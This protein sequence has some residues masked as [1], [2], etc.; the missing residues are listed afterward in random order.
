MAGLS[1]PLKS[2]LAQLLLPSTTSLPTNP[3]DHSRHRQAIVLLFLPSQLTETRYRL[4]LV[5]KCKD[6]RIIRRIR[7][8]P[9][10]VDCKVGYSNV[11]IAV[12]KDSGHLQCLSPHRFQ[13]RW[14]LPCQTLSQ[15]VK[16]HGTLSSP[17]Y[18][19]S[20][21]SPSFYLLRVGSKVIRKIVRWAQVGYD[22]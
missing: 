14:C 5:S 7:L 18:A 15:E 10:S 2:A 21:P 13:P 20:S 6:K 17:S 3:I 19:S 8:L 4:H 9:D 16:I 11:I 1:R 12:T 22:Q